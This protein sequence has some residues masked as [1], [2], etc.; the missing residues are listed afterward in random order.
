MP[1][2][3]TNAIATEGTP[4]A[5]EDA[6]LI[7]EDSLPLASLYSSY[8]VNRGLEVTVVHTGSEALERLVN[9]SFGLLLLDLS[10][11]DMHGFAVLRQISALELPVATIVVTSDETA[12][13]A[14]EA[15][16]L[17]ALDYL[18]KPIAV[19]RLVLTVENVLEQRRL[20][21]MLD[22][23]RER[24]D[25]DHFDDMIGAS[26]VMQ[27]VYS[28]IESA[29]ASRASIFITGESGTGKELCARAIHNHSD[30]AKNALI[31]LN[32]AAIPKDLMESEI[33]GHVKGAFTGAHTERQGAAQ[34]ADGGTLFLDELCEMDIELQ[35][36]L[37]R[38]IQTGTFQKVGSSKSQS[39]DIR[40]VC[41]TNRNPLEEVRAG[42]FR[43]DLYYRLHVIP[44]RLPALR[45]RGG[46]VLKIAE[47]FLATIARREKKQFRE[48]S[49]EAADMLVAYPWPG[50][51]R[52]LENVIMNTVILNDG[53]RVTPD[54]LPASF[55]SPLISQSI[56]GADSQNG[57]VDVPSH[58]TIRP[59]WLEE[60]R[61]I[62]RAIELCDGNIPK[63]A[64]HLELSASTLYR[65]KQNWN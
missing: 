51:I 53:E 15:V 25:R 46:D 49:R 65:K 36:K 47:T 59:F 19:N 43:E 39:V 2:A 21:Q 42:R 60:R 32:C 17:G 35:S 1:D 54:M 38:F 52:E 37:L 28:T 22:N 6:I 58:T 24:V 8:L 20:A 61:I 30:R 57:S 9:Q 29:A 27:G 18:T 50:N 26:P 41:A 13:S 56:P 23:Y 5:A 33:F 14:L 12:E 16:A 62:E 34:L 48:F 45:E 40:F 7:V 44:I 55:N 63:A 64:A 11:P 4:R 31:T 3:R 10:L